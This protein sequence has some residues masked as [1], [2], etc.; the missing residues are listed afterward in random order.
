MSEQITG[1]PAGAG[2]A[3]EQLLAWYRDA[4]VDETL[5]DH[6]IDRFAATEHARTAV[7]AVPRQ[8]EVAAYSSVTPPPAG[9]TPNAGAV[10]NR[11]VNAQDAPDLQAR[12]AAGGATDLAAL[13]ESLERFEGCALKHT[14]KT[15]VF[16]DGN[17]NA[18]VMFIGEAPGADEDR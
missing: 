6:P 10:P 4:G 3:V 14:A 13:R 7:I 9:Q 12:A 5:V 18:D 11:P 2:Q 15:L 8:S 17:P 1:H 16:A